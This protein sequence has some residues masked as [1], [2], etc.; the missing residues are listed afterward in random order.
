VWFVLIV[1]KGVA[2]LDAKE[3]TSDPYE[4]NNCID[5]NFQYWSCVRLE[6]LLLCI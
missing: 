2:C 1:V 3:T 4:C 6:I 5:S